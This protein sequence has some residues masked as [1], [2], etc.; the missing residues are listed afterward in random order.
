MTGSV[1]CWAAFGTVLAAEYQDPR[2]MPV[3]RLSVDAYAVQHPGA[4]A[5]RGAT[6]SVGLHLARLCVQ[7]DRGLSGTHAN[8]V[9]LRLGQVKAGL[10]RS[11]R[12]PASASP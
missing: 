2:L 6:Q 12:P 1:A 9:M 10:P 7:L 11:L 3:H 8:A 4:A 5:N